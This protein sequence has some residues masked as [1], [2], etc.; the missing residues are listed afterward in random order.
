MEGE[1]KLDGLR[2]WDGNP[3]VHLLKADQDLNAMLLERCE[4]GTVLRILPEP[5]QDVVIAELL[6]RLWRSPSPPHPFRPLSAMTASEH[7]DVSRC[8]TVA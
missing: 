1:H 8:R 7:R 6:R 5:E 3:T 2:F 4:P